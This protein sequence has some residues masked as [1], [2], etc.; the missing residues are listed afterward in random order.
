MPAMEVPEAVPSGHRSL[1]AAPDSITS[2]CGLQLCQ[3]DGVEP[4]AVIGFSLRF[5]QHMS[6]ADSLW[7]TLAARKS[8]MTDFPKD[9]LNLEAFYE[10]GTERLNG[11]RLMLF[12]MSLRAN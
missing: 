4:I 5:P 9:R 12:L 3:S 11:V 10:P 8:V 1:G 6:S 7:E 2:D